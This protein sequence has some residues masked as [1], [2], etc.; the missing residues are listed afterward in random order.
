[1]SSP[2]DIVNN[3]LGRALVPY[4]K[5]LYSGSASLARVAEAL[6]TQLGREVTVDTVVQTLQAHAQVGTAFADS[7]LSMARTT[8]EAAELAAEKAAEQAIAKGAEEALV[9]AARRRAWQ[10]VVQQSVKQ[11]ATRGVQATVS[12]V[13]GASMG[14]WILLLVGAGAVLIGGYMWANHMGDKPVKAGAGMSGLHP[15]RGPN[16]WTPAPI[17][18]HDKYYI[19]AV[20][21]SGWS[22][23][24]GRPS[25]VEGRPAGTLTDGGTG[26]TPVEYKKLVETAFDNSDAALAYLKARISPGHE[27]RW[28]GTWVKFE[29]AEYRTVH[30]R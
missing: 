20:N 9:Q 15:G 29:G 2:L 25:D 6:S 12:A 18:Q 14:F 1:M 23:Y 4:I 27:S 5:S 13:L 22:L 21:T 16:A 19:Y 26:D 28:T 3:P 8:L 7:A 10:T 17:G 30:L 11:V 24:V